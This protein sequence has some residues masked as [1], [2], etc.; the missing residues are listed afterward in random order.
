MNA[1]PSIRPRAQ[2]G[3]FLL[4][5]L[6]GLLIFSFGILGIVALQAQSMRYTNDAE[7]RAEATYLAN[8]LISQMWTDFKPSDRSGFKS[9]YDSTLGGAGYT[10]FNLEVHAS[11]AHVGVLDPVVT[12]DDAAAPPI[13]QQSNSSSIV[14]VK[15]SWQMPGDTAVHNYITT[16]VVGLN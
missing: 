14:S 4:E 8:S 10:A 11:L 5:A 13:P 1:Q 15:I 2:R 9:K 6:V 7:V 16:G 12:V 3:A